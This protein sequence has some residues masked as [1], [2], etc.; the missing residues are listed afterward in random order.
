QPLS[1]GQVIVATWHPH[2]TAV[3]EAIREFGLELQVIFNK[4]AVMILPANVNKASGLSVALK[5]MGLS[6]HNVVGVGDAENDHAFL[7]RCE[8]GVAVDNAIPS[9]KEAADYVT[10]AARGDGVAELVDM[11]LADDLAQLAP[12]LGRHDLPLGHDV[13]G[14]PVT[15]PAYGATVLI[16]GTSGGGKSTIVTGLIERLAEKGYQHCVVDPEGDYSKY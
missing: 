8:C 12:R 10:A 3:L 1:V 9:L 5:E 7:A 2:E 13:E 14:R 16:A 4:D 15:V 11:M 6:P